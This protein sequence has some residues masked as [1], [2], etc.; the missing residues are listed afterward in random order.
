MKKI[1]LAEHCNIVTTAMQI[2]VETE[3]ADCRLKIAETKTQLLHQLRDNEYD[4]V[5]IGPG[6]YSAGTAEL[7]LEINTLY[8]SL[9]LVFISSYTT[10]H[11]RDNTHLSKVLKGHL[12]HDSPDYEIITA[13]RKIMNGESYF[14]K[15]VVM[16]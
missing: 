7:L 9:P 2:I 5:I 3:L 12:F 14:S 16:G 13:L 4:V 1:L 15:S 10:D 11:F 6:K 8:P